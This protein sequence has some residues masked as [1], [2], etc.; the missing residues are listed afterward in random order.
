NPSPQVLD[1][2]ATLDM[3]NPPGGSEIP[4]N[5][6]QP[7]PQ[8][9]PEAVATQPQPA[10]TPATT[11]EGLITN[12]LTPLSQALYDSYNSLFNTPST[13]QSPPSDR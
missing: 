7:L 8:N 5:Q 3:T 6:P 12:V 13:P 1:N 11:L 10:Q 2:V 4:A 9:A